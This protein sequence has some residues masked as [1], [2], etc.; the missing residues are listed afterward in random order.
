L[1]ILIITVWLKILKLSFCCISRECMDCCCFI[2]MIQSRR[3]F[4]QLCPRD[5]IVSPVAQKSS[6]IFEEPSLSAQSL[7]LS[8]ALHTNTTHMHTHTQTRV[9]A[10]SLDK[11]IGIPHLPSIGRQGHGKA[12]ADVLLI[13]Y[14]H[15]MSMRTALARMMGISFASCSVTFQAWLSQIHCAHVSAG[16]Q[17]T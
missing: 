9:R 4:R 7:P 17:L 8:R 16:N 10:C 12:M 15:I 3:N 13:P 14:P 6:M 2:S 1:H 5:Y 11:I